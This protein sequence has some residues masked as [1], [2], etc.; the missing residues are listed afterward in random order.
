MVFSGVLLGIGGNLIRNF[1]Q[2]TKYGKHQDIFV[3]SFMLLG[4]ILS[5]VILAE[6]LMW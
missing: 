2:D 5:I 6:M 4:S 3:Y 1:V